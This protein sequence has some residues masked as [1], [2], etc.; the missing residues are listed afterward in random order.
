MI[1]RFADESYVITYGIEYKG[2][3]VRLGSNWVDITN[4]IEREIG[5]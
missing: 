2:V 5:E 4:S 1:H 3:V